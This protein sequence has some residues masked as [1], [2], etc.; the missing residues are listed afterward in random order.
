MCHTTTARTA[1]AHAQPDVSSDDT[2]RRPERVDTA[3]QARRDAQRVARNGAT[4]WWICRAGKLGLR[5]H[6]RTS[7]A[8][9]EASELR[10]LVSDKLSRFA[11]ASSRRT[12]VQTTRTSASLRTPTAAE[13]LIV[14]IVQVN[15]DERLIPTLSCNIDMYL[16]KIKKK[17][18]HLHTFNSIL[19]ELLLQ[20]Q[21]LAPDFLTTI[22]KHRD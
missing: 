8:T 7:R 1:L 11:C 16:S 15:V 22:R 13:F 18:S 6:R 12:E 21:T 5:V 2:A 19:F 9:R 17:K 4:D 20:T 10:R 3:N 14:C